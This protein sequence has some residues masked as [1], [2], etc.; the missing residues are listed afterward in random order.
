MV[1]VGTGTFESRYLKEGWP[2][3]EGLEA[4]TTKQE[5]RKPHLE[6]EIDLIPDKD[7]VLL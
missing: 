4:G 3:E 5:G 2:I 7:K 6:P 1:E